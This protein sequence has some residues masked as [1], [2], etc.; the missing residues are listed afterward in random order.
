MSRLDQMI[1]E[2]PIRDRAQVLGWLIELF[3]L[4]GGAEARLVTAR[5]Q[6][7]AR[8]IFNVSGVT[9]GPVFG[10]EGQKLLEKDKLAWTIRLGI[11]TLNGTATG[12][13][14]TERRAAFL[15][16]ARSVDLPP[17]SR[18]RLMPPRRQ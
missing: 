1:A 4:W 12:D 6:E 7:V 18:E 13:A 14:L 9:P 11:N 10:P 8:L 5:R 2:S 16:A 3:E 17:A 15:K